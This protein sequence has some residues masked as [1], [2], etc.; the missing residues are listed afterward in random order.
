[1][2]DASPPAPDAPQRRSDAH[3]APTLGVALMLSGVLLV[4]TLDLFAK[5]LG[6]GFFGPADAPPL[7]EIGAP[8][9]ALQISW[10]RFLFQTALLLP[11]VALLAAHGLR[12]PKRFGLVALRGALLAIATVAFFA[13][14][15]SLGLAEAT[16]IFFV[17]PFILT[18]LSALFLRET[19]G[20]RRVAAIAV[21]LF[22]AVIII[23]PNFIEVGWA[24]FYPLI[25]AL[26]FALY[27]MLTRMLAREASPLVLQFWSGV[28]SCA[29]LT[30]ALGLADVAD[31]DDAAPIVLTERHW[32]VL[33]AAG[34]VAAACHLVMSAA[35]RYSEA[36]LLAPL[37]Y[38]EIVGAAL[39]GYYVFDE[40]L[41]EATLL[42]L[43]LIV[44]AGV[45][46][47]RRERAL[48]RAGR[49]SPP[50][51]ITRSGR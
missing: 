25:T 51:R 1:M 48:K 9:P 12:P 50:R 14:L 5:A 42:G 21:G 3:D 44:G 16:A 10:G 22:G 35:F 4:P 23:R 15:R 49:R 8:T 34:V 40:T 45:F 24:A 17:E 43:G 6:Q 27:L 39:I 36:S 37:Q 33:F 41:D 11:F 31:I 32:L 30:L 47:I 7:W 28:V 13:G 26:C 38:F 46:V 19:I 18:V 20:W 29:L 2:T